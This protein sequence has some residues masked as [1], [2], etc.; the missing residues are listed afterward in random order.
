MSDK[1][2]ERIATEVY[3][4]LGRYRSHYKEI[5]SLMFG[6]NPD[7]YQIRLLSLGRDRVLVR[8]NLVRLCLD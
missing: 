1:N 3:T 6:V 8:I 2:S 7:T 5:V 4:F